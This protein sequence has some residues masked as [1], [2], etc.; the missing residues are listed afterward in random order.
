MSERRWAGS[1]LT[2]VRPAGPPSRYPGER[3]GLPERGTGAVAG[4]GVRIVALF[5]DWALCTAIALAA[6]HSRWWTYAIFAVEVYLLTALTGF[7]VGKRLL[8]LRVVRLDGK[9]VGFGWAL[10]RTVLLLAVIPAFIV[11]RDMRGLHDRAAN[12]VVIRV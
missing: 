2:G 1:W 5:I 8:S 6:L 11:D 12:T 7:T 9:P 10:V 3:L 4:F